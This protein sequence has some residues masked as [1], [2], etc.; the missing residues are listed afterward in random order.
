MLAYRRSAGVRERRRKHA[1]ECSKRMQQINALFAAVLRE[2]IF[3]RA[4]P[5]FAARRFGVSARGQRH[6]TPAF[7]GRV[8]DDIHP[9]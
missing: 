9:A 7:V 6:P 2:R 8:D 3:D 4:S 5:R 1:F